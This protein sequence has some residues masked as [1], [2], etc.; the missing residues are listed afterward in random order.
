[1]SLPKGWGEVIGLHECGW[2]EQA[3]MAAQWLVAFDCLP[4]LVVLLRDGLVVGVA[5]VA[6]VQRCAEKCDYSL[7]RA[8]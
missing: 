7:Q 8:R 4:S 3:R 2:V 1:M 5:V 6:R